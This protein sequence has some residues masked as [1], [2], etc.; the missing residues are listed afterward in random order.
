MNSDILLK[1]ENLSNTVKNIENSIN[2]IEEII[3]GVN[4][5]MLTF[6]DSDWT[7]NQKKKIDEEYMP[8]LKTL[9]NDYILYLKKH[10]NYLK[11]AIMMYQLSDKQLQEIIER[12][13]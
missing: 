9:S 6:N 3:N 1:Y 10:L 8:Y 12:G 7:G 4:K 2:N 13:N 5:S 11:R